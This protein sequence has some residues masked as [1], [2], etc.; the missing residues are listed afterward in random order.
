[1]SEVR[2]T[3]IATLRAGLRD[4][5]ASAIDDVVAEYTA[6]FQEGAA[7]NRSDQEIATALGDPVALAGEL[8]VEM[9]IERWESQRTV[10]SAMSTITRVVGHGVL[11]ATLLFIVGPLLVLLA[12]SLLILIVSLL[13][14]GVWLL[15]DGSSLDLPGGMASTLLAAAGSIFA[16][17][18]LAAFL[19]LGVIGLVN[20]LA[21]Y[22]RLHYK[23]LSHPHRPGSKS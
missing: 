23:F 14:A 13:C 7:A 15:F 22:A 9:Q 3:F 19:A 6:H 5:P 16:S 11:G 10:S 12:L 1:M 8:R 21:R 4:A 17:V 2:A 20:A 18:S